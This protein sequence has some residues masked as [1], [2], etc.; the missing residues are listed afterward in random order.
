M[1]ASVY[2]YLIVCLNEFL[3]LFFFPSFS[4]IQWIATSHSIRQEILR[5]D[6]ADDHWKITALL[7]TMEPWWSNLQTQPVLEKRQG[8]VTAVIISVGDIPTPQ[9]FIIVDHLL[10]IVFHACCGCVRW[11]GRVCL[12]VCAYWWMWMCVVTDAKDIISFWP[13]YWSYNK[14]LHCIICKTNV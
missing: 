7:I 8:F 3:H 5:F 12:Y 1:I 11:F 13:L 9:C 10:Q 6:F 2:F 4:S 14:S